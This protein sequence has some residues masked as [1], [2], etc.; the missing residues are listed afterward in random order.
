MSRN[1]FLKFIMISFV[2]ISL[3]IIKETAVSANINSQK[4]VNEPGV[5]SNQLVDGDSNT[6]VSNDVQ[7]GFINRNSKVYY[8]LNGQMV[9]GEQ[10]INNNW[11]YFDKETGA[12]STGFQN[13]DNKTVYY[14]SQGQMIYGEQKIDNNWY[15]F[16]KETGAMSTSFQT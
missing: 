7:N 12:M 16:D 15:Y 5:S 13:L 9:Y 2:L 4:N 11:Y 14:N 10:K 1:T 3:M 6:S 8:Y